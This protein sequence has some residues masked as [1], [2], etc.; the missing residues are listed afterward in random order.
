MSRILLELSDLFFN[1]S[2]KNFNDECVRDHDTAE[3]A[4]NALYSAIL[5]DAEEFIEKYPQT[6]SFFGNPTSQELAEDFMSRL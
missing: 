4:K 5:K 2:N 3:K 6:I 1:Y